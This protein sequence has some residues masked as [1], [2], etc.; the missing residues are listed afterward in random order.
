M[1]DHID[2]TNRA[3]L[4]AGLAERIAIC[5]ATGISENGRASLVV[6]GGRTPKPMFDELSKKDIDWSKVTITLAD[7][8]WVPEDDPASNAAL[9]RQ[10]LLIN[11][12]AAAH[13]IPLYV[14]D[15]SAQE[16]ETALGAGLS[17]M[18]RPFDCVILGMGD[19]GHTAS[20]FPDAPELPKAMRAIRGEVCLAMTPPSQSQTR[21][22]L[23]LPALMNCK[24]LFLLIA[25]E[26]KKQVLKQAMADG[27]TE[28]MPIRGVLRQTIVPLEIHWAA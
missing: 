6:S 15:R 8:R 28:A 12:A 16:S 5:L 10:S 13:F 19:D 24:R 2:H 1:I 7:E 23:T 17:S 11:N 22:T 14:F 4:M 21:I 26:G 20:L 27:P 3:A 18:Q 9:V 25:G